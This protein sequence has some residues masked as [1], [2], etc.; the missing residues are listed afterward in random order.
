MIMKHHRLHPE[1]GHNMH[2]IRLVRGGKTLYTA[3][4]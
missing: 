4:Y 3:V 2:Y 1:M